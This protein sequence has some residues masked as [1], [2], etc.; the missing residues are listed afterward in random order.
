[1]TLRFEK[2]LKLSC[3]DIARSYVLFVIEKCAVFMGLRGLS[4]N[5]ICAKAIETKLMFVSKLK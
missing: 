4:S 2:R 3:F 1:M 5:F